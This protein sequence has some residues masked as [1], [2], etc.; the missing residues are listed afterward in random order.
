MV[1]QYGNP[2]KTIA[3]HAT[4]LNFISNK[5]V[6]VYNFLNKLSIVTKSRYNRS[7]KDSYKHKNLSSAHP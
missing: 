6:N 3:D 5:L 4:L 2:E 1:V 7:Y